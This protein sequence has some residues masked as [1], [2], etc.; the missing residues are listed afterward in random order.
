MARW[1][2][3]LAG[4]LLGAVVVAI[5]A[6]AYAAWRRTSDASVL[7]PVRTGLL[8]VPLPR[9]DSLE[10]PVVQQVHESHRWFADLVARRDHSETDLAEGYGALGQLYHAYG[11]IDAAEASYSNATRLAPNDFRWSHLLG[12]LYQQNGRLEQ[13]I[14]FYLAALESRSDDFPARVYLG[15]VYLRL[16]RRAEAREQFENVL[17]RY[18]AA[19]LNG[20]GEV[21]LIEGRF[22]EA[23]RHFE[24][25]LQRV[26][27]ASRIH[28]SLAMAYRGL[29][30]LDETQAHLERVGTAGIQVADPV[31]DNLPRVHLIQGQFAY[32]AGQFKAAADAY[33]K[34][35]VA[36]PTSVTASVNLGLALAALGDTEGASQQLQAALRLDPENITAHFAL[37]T[38]LA[39]QERHA[40]AVDHLRAVISRAPDD[41]EAN[42][43]LTHSLLKLGRNDE[44]VDSQAAGRR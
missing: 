3:P 14:K 25:A 32:Q 38:L 44:A 24:A 20:L 27:R 9:L 11:F 4:W 18:P 5:L 16:G 23:V 31:V 43:E 21:A 30:R 17:A 37:G 15:E 13:S 2:F 19:A 40:E 12:Y 36:A 8:P 10:P 22:G 26:P 7:P 1:R 29:N 34:A 28:Y 35:M 6:Y 39:R 41:V 42:R 33:R